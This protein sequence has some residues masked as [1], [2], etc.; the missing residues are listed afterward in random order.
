MW[1]TD[2]GRQYGRFSLPRNSRG[3]ERDYS[4]ENK[5]LL[6][7]LFAVKKLCNLAMCVRIKRTDFSLQIPTCFG[8]RC[9]KVGRFSYKKG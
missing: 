8:P 6:L 9:S 3:N 5:G 4:R 1:E 2:P 7:L